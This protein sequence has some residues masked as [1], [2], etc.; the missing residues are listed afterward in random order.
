MAPNSPS[1][2][3]SDADWTWGIWTASSYHSDVVNVLFCDGSVSRIANEIDTTVWRAL[4]TRAG[5]EVI[6]DDAF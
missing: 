1:C 4:G 3:V 5:Q 2:M 6:D